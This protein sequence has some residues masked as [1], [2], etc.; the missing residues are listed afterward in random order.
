MIENII[1]RFLNTINDDK[2]IDLHNNVN[3]I[4]RQR[5]D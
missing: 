3:R 4:S 1:E 5:V 2:A